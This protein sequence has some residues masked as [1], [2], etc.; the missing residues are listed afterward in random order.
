MALLEAFGQQGVAVTANDQVDLRIV[1]GQPLVHSDPGMGDQDQ[2]VILAG[3]LLHHAVHGLAQ[4]LDAP[5]V[6][7]VSH[8]VSRGQAHQRDP[9]PLLAGQKQVALG[10]LRH[11]FIFFAQVGQDDR[12][13]SVVKQVLQDLVRVG[14]AFIVSDRDG[15][16][17]E[18]IHQADVDL[19]LSRVRQRVGPVHEVTGVKSKDLVSISVFLHVMQIA[20]DLWEMLKV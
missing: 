9:R 19:A 4:H 3:N 7:P 18:V 14:D 13:I 15:I 11:R 6:W 8:R 20:P 17:V 12:K 1:L 16:I 10:P 5:V 2:K